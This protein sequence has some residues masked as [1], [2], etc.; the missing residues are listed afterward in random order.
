MDNSDDTPLNLTTHYA[1]RVAAGVDLPARAAHFFS[2]AELA[3]LG[4]IR[5]VAYKTA[6]NTCPLSVKDIARLVEV[7]PRTAARAISL[8]I[9]AGLIERDG[10]NIINRGIEY[11]VG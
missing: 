5:D 8:A 6:D 10:S 1:Q 2:Q 9:A 11:K 7:Q 4:A 3:V